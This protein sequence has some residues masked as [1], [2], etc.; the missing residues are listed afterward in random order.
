MQMITFIKNYDGCLWILHIWSVCM[1]ANDF[2][3]VVSVSI[4]LFG[5][6]G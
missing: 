4:I 1:C 3:L 6:R 5:V 2:F